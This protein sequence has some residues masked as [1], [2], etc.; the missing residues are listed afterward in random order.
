MLTANP[1]RARLFHDKSLA[2]EDIYEPFVRDDA[3][4]QQLVWVSVLRRACSGATT[5]LYIEYQYVGVFMV[6][7]AVLISLFLGSVEGFSS[8]IQACTYNPFKKFKPALATALFS[9]VPFVLNVVP[10]VI[11][12][13]L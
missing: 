10:S 5:F 1:K 8:T 2:S 7:F 4:L 3:A 6:A 12:G 11:S 9:I 13:F